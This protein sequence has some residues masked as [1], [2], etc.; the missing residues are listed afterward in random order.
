VFLDPPFDAGLWGKAAARLEEGGWL[1]P[2]AFVY[3]EVPAT[4]GD[5]EAAPPPGLPATLKPWRDGTAGEVGYHLL[6]RDGRPA[7][8]EV[9]A[10]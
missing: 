8:D 9:S 10:T 6:R 2:E 5:T 7:S 1:A 3:L 4:R